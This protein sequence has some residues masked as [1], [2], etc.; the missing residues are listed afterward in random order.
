MMTIFFD[1]A[2]VV[3]RKILTRLKS[4]CVES[5]L[6]G[7]DIRFHTQ[8]Q[9]FNHSLNDLKGYCTKVTITENV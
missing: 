5:N 7:S 6:S 9:D 4:I 8:K 3:H 1:E 2:V